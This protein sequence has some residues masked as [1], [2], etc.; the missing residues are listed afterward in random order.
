MQAKHNISTKK[1]VQYFE[2]SFKFKYLRQCNE[3]HCHIIN[4]SLKYLQSLSSCEWSY[5]TPWI[6]ALYKGVCLT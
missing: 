5:C 2:C 4:D 6:N 1:C 3:A